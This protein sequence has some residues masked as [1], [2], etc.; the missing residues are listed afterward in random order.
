MNQ[1]DLKK[2]LKPLVKQLVKEAMQE[3]LSTVITEIIKQ[4]GGRTVVEQRQPVVNEDLRKERQIE[5]QKALEEK[6]KLLEEVSK[7]AYG[8]INIFEGTTPIAAAGNPEQKINEARAGDPLSDSDPSDPGID[9]NGLLRM[10]GG[11][12]QIK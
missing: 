1:N 4:T 12:K 7:K 10:T 8:G 9:I 6:R 5:K 3:E 2:M 11:W